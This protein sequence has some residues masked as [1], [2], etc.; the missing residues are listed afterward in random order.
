[1]DDL[2]TRLE[3]VNPV[4]DPGRLVEKRAESQRLYLR[5]QQRKES[6]M[7]DTEIEQVTNLPQT[8]PA[9]R[10]LLIGAAAAVIVLIAGIAAAVVTRSDG[11]EV[12][13][14]PRSL[15]VTFDG[16]RCLYSGPEQLTVGEVSL[17]FHN[18]S[19]ETAWVDFAVID[20]GYTV[21]DVEA[22]VADPPSEDRPTW[23][24]A[25]WSRNF[26]SPGISSPPDG[27]ATRS[28]DPGLHVLVCGA[29]TPYR[30]FLASDLTVLP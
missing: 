22:F 19:G 29:D 11:G 10:G 16:D 5:V 14:A 12:A 27:P 30:P 2:L 13:A 20:A 28:L 25:V 1:V 3:R 21:A 7:T 6:G 8:P 4:P 17:R 9:R 24:R 26:V 23:T 18:K 15:E